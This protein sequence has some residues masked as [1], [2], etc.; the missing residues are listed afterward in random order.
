MNLSAKQNNKKIAIW[1][2][3][4]VLLS[5]VA[6]GL[7]L[8]HET[9]TSEPNSTDKDTA[10]QPLYW[11]APM[12]PNYRRDQPGQSP[13]GMDLVPVYQTEAQTDSPGTVTIAPNVVNNLGV[14]T[15]T[16]AS[17]VMETPIST[18]G[19]IQ[20]NQDNMVHIHARVEG[21]IDKLHVKAA[22]ITVVKD[23][24]LYD[25]YSPQ[26]V[27]AQEE[28]LLAVNRKNSGL[29]NAA[30]ARLVALQMPRQ[31]IEQL[32]ST[33][34]VMQSVTF[35]APQGGVIDNLNV[36]QGFYVKPD[37]TL[38]S[39]GALDDVWVEAEVFERLAG[40]VRLGLPVTM[41]LDYLPGQQWQGQVDFIYPALS[42]QT[43]TL[44]VRLR[45][46]NSQRLFKPNM[47]AQIKIQA[48]SEQAVLLVPMQAVIRLGEQNRVV[49]ALGNGRY[50]SVEVG[51]GLVSGGLAQITSG[52]QEGDEVVLSAQFL[53]DSESSIS[54][55][56]SRMT[57]YG[58]PA[59]EMD[60]A[61]EDVQSASVNGV[62][63]NIDPANKILNISRSAIEKWGRG[64]ATLD[65]T[66]LDGIDLSKL[67]AGDEIFFTFEIHNGDFVIT[68]LKVM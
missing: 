6:T 7:F 39:I 67:T 63:N 36:S 33:R 10:K 34:Q 44:R 31:A 8:R 68:E 46:D 64:P 57:A 41:Q 23:Q 11:V 37:K 45:F 24:P 42:E 52:I 58:E 15:V 48:S 12:D 27:N 49:L 13:M 47:F 51:L 28:Y 66:V 26:L 25:L 38:M 21:W 35:R 19:Y 61:M 55:D 56:F 18:V 1:T 32:K 9:A 16:V 29:T 3:V 2:L 14:R 59:P 40:Q 30:L 5:S 54:S 65:F 22:G 4:G 50:K 20:Y 43:R 60:M 17:Q 53:I 62:I